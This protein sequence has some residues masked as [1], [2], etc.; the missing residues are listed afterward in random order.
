MPE[1]GTRRRQVPEGSTTERDAAARALQRFARQK[2][3]QS[4]AAHRTPISLIEAGWDPARARLLGP[5]AA[6]VKYL[7]FLYRLSRVFGRGAWS[8]GSLRPVLLASRLLWRKEP[9]RRCRGGKN[10]AAEEEFRTQA[11]LA[12]KMLRWYELYVVILRRLESATPSVLH[13]FCG[14]GGDSCYTHTSTG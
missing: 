3:L 6:H 11:A 9:R 7:Q 12:E 14:A 1:A 5:L 13:A 2:F 4:V 8:R 10:L